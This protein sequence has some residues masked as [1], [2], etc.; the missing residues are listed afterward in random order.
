MVKYSQTESGLAFEY[1]LAQALVDV[2]PAIAADSEKPYKT[3]ARSY[4][5]MDVGV[6]D[7]LKTAAREAI[8]FLCAFEDG[9]RDN[10][11]GIVHIQSA[12][13]ARQRA[14]VRD[15]VVRYPNHELGISAKNESLEQRAP[16]LSD[17]IDFGEKWLDEPVSDEYWRK[18]KPVFEDLRA[19]QSQGVLWRDLPNPKKG[20][21]YQ[22]ILSAFMAE[23]RRIYEVC[24]NKMPE[25]LVRYVLGKFDFYQVTKEN[26]SVSIAAFNLSNNLNWGNRVPLP[27]RVL[28]FDFIPDSKNTILLVFDKGW[29]IRLRI[30]NASSK[31]EPSL[32]F[33]ITIEGWP[34]NIARHVIPRKLYSQHINT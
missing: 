24:S 16:R 13:V 11:Q 1:A 18:I 9:L 34:K 15:I 6:R 21:I 20:G 23:V 30:H 10:R 22:A 31:V 28:F 12:H 3:A 33:S 2:T 5:K 8:T 26:G 19:L 17:K 29:Q 14:D 7:D 4:E 25:S 32:K 27:K